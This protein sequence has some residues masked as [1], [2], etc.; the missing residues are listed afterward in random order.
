MCDYFLDSRLI[1]T[2]SRTT[3]TTLIPVQIHI[4]P[5]IH[6]PVW[7]IIGSKFFFLL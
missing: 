4:P 3:T 7:F 6:V 5:P 1:M 2:V